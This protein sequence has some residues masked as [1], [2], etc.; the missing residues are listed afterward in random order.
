MAKE[1]AVLK[2]RGK[3]IELPVL[4]DTFQNVFVDISKLQPTTGMCT[5]DPGYT[6]TACCESTITYINGGKGILLYRGYPIE[7]LAESSD[8]IDCAYLLLNG[9]LPNKSEYSEL[10][11]QL[12]FHNMVVRR[13]CFICGGARVAWG[14]GCNSK[15]VMLRALRDT[16]HAHVTNVDNESL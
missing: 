2:I 14:K 4:E 6:S 16:R 3:E 8:F 5:F 11:G 10:D 1:T 7:Q 15:T 13:I 9:K 12:K